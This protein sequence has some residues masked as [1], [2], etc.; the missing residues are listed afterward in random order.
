MHQ[1]GHADVRE[2]AGVHYHR[3][4]NVCNGHEYSA[5]EPGS[6]C[7]WVRLAC[8]AS[9]C[10]YRPGVH[11]Q[12]FFCWAEPPDARNLVFSGIEEPALRAVHKALQHNVLR[13]RFDKLDWF[14]AG[15]TVKDLIR[16]SK[17]P[18]D[19]FR[20]FNLCMETL[21]DHGAHTYGENWNIYFCWSEEDWRKLGFEQHAYENYLATVRQRA[22]ANGAGAHVDRI[23]GAYKRWGPKPASTR[24]CL[25]Q[26]FSGA[27][28]PAQ[29]VVR[30]SLF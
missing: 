29:T 16:L 13:V 12:V 22:L 23:E 15:L 28:Q 5:G 27:A 9:C 30:R 26:P 25:F 7:I 19:I 20:T 21:V 11:A 24:A 4:R 18:V 1:L 6:R 2:N 17:V 3:R 10:A 8:N 14:E